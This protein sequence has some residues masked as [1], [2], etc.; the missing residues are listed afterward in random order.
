MAICDGSLLITLYPIFLLDEAE[1]PGNV[2]TDGDGG[3]EICGL[4][5]NRS[6]FVTARADFA[7][8]VGAQCMPILDD[9]QNDEDLSEEQFQGIVERIQTASAGVTTSLKLSNPA[10]MREYMRRGS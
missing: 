1:L 3:E 8:G 5:S 6:L 9:V 2:W 10:V 4:R 7:C